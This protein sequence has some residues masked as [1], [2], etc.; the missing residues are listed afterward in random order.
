MGVRDSL[1]DAQPGEVMR[2]M[3]EPGLIVRHSCDRE[4]VGFPGDRVRRVQGFISVGGNATSLKVTLSNLK[5]AGAAENID[6]LRL[7]LLDLTVNEGLH[8]SMEHALCPLTLSNKGSG[9]LGVEAAASLLEELE[10]S[11]GGRGPPSGN[12]GL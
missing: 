11:K 6:G 2:E 10:R 1:S 9:E 4:T 12:M 7:G 8:P 5:G 3:G